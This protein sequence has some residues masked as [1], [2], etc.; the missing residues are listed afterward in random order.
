LITSTEIKKGLG[1]KMKTDYSD[2][3][4][5]YLVRNRVSTTEVADCLGKTGAL[6][7]VMPCVSG[8]YRA[9]KIAWV[10]AYDESNWSLHEQL[11]KIDEG[12]IIFVDSLNCGE[13]AIFGELVSKYI[14]L[15][16]QAVAIVVQGKLRDAAALLR[17]KWPIWC[18]GYTPMGCFNKRP[19]KEVDPEWHKKRYEALNDAIA[20]CDD[21]GVVIIPHDFINEEF[22]EKLKNIEDQEDIWFDRLDHY[23]ESTFDIVCKKNYLQDELYMNI[24]NKNRSK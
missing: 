21:C 11:E 13:R 6:P 16:R 18:T 12:K 8:Y 14:L 4:I 19:E 9:G 2:L 1:G 24:R 20:V 23:K 17:E 7:G 10:Y 5:D 22:L 3:I 15:Y